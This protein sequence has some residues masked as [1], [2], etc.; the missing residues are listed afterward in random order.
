MNSENEIITV[1]LRFNEV[2]DMINQFSR[3]NNLNQN[4]AQSLLNSI[5]I[6]AYPMWTQQTDKNCVLFDESRVSEI[7]K[8]I[9]LNQGK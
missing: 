9:L 8:N 2:C 4:V 1:L 6:D 7:L 5:V 3:A